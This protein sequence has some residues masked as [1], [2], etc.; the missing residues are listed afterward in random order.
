M[1]NSD[2]IRL[3]FAP[4][5]SPDTR[6]LTASAEQEKERHRLTLEALAEVDAGRGIPHERIKEWPDSL[7]LGQPS[8]VPTC[9]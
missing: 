8:A 5:P 3:G 4:M 7:N 9:D 1:I 6:V 2:S